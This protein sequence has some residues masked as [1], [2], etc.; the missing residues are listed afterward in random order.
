MT[1]V[2]WLP[3]GQ[4]FRSRDDRIADTIDVSNDLCRL[5]AIEWWKFTYVIFVWM[6]STNKF[7]KIENA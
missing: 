7:L 2:Y 6:R 5:I 3:T 1:S 4:R